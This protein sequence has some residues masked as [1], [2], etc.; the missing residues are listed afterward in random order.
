MKKYLFLLLLLL[1]GF[2]GESENPWVKKLTR[3][4]LHRDS[5]ALFMITISQRNKFDK[6]STSYQT[7]VYF[8]G[9][10]FIGA[11]EF[12]ADFPD[13]GF[14]YYKLSDTAFLFDKILKQYYTSDIKRDSL[15]YDFDL[16][17]QDEVLGPVFY[18]S[19]YQPGFMSSVAKDF[20]TYKMNCIGLTYKNMPVGSLQ[21][22]GL[23]TKMT[24]LFAKTCR[25][26]AVIDTI[27][28]C[29]RSLYMKMDTSKV[30]GNNPI[31]I[32]YNFDKTTIT[33]LTQDSIRQIV[34]NFKNKYRLSALTESVNFDDYKKADRNNTKPIPK[35]VITD[36]ASQKYML[37][38]LTT[39]GD[40][41]HLKDYKGKYIL[42]DFWFINCPPCIR[43]IPKV[44][45]IL[46]QFKDKNLIVIGINPF[47]KMDAIKDVVQKKDMRYL[48]CQSANSIDKIFKV[49][50]FPTYLLVSPDQKTVQTITL[51][52]E[53]DLEN[54]IKQ[55][56]KKLK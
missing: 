19:L 55:L 2:S 33:T 16:L 52:E 10:K 21:S 20:E 36:E 31:S 49:P 14:A 11:N 24:D 47:D 1:I 37:P 54:F 51:H 26:T 27:S 18:T 48:V 3:K 25:Y 22:M 13:F 39:N 50:Y 41:I 28:R 6:D 44:N 4:P 15:L 35:S 30:M 46:E 9:K 45:A 40:T 38:L 42:L 7:M 29:F 12:Y 23:E 43:G 8:S 17:L 56:E 53:K 34:S 5:T 32:N